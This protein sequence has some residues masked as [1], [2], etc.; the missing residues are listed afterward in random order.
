MIDRFGRLGNLPKV[1]Q[2][3]TQAQAMDVLTNGLEVELD[4]ALRAVESRDLSLVR[5]L[6]AVFQRYNFS[7]DSGAYAGFTAFAY[8]ILQYPPEP[9]A[10]RS[11]LPVL[12]RVDVG[13]INLIGSTENPNNVNEAA[14][15]DMVKDTAEYNPMLIAQVQAN[16]RGM[17]LPAEQVMELFIGV[18]FMHTALRRAAV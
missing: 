15:T 18:S 13:L 9:N 12:P 4:D 8:Q 1:T 17:E 14:L 3:M 11:V 5:S 7:V 2:F 16:G 6:Q 10:P